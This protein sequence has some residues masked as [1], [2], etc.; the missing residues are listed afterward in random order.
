MADVATSIAAIQSNTG[1]M[2]QDIT[3]PSGTTLD[4]IRTIAE[5]PLRRIIQL[6]LALTRPFWVD[7]ALNRVRCTGII[8]SGTVTTVSTVTT[9]TTVTGV[10]NFDSYQARMSVVANNQC[11]WASLVR[12]RIG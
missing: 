6:L 1:S 7:L 9:V 5:T 11:A 10:T 2:S 8:E 12:A 4:D 3:G